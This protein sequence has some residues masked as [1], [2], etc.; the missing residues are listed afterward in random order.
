MHLGLCL[1]RMRAFLRGRE[2]AF[3]GSNIPYSTALI[4]L[5]LRQTKQ[6]LKPNKPLSET[7]ECGGSGI[8][9][10]A[11]SAMSPVASDWR[12]C[13]YNKR[14]TGTNW[15]WIPG[16]Q[17]RLPPASFLAVCSQKQ[18]VGERRPLWRCPQR[19]APRFAEFSALDMFIVISRDE[20]A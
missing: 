3:P 17:T 7:A 6:T 15:T 2:G 8:W 5:E 11:P 14:D 16:N 9:R 20:A 10:L 1:W 13:Q 19:V 18:E 12:W 4:L